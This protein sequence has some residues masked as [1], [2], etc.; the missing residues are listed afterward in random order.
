MKVQ[1]YLLPLPQI[2]LLLLLFVLFLFL[3][4]INLLTLRPHY[5]FGQRIMDEG[6]QHLYML[7]ESDARLQYSVGV[8]A[9]VDQPL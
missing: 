9:S 8:T 3:L 2:L 5:I 7:D 6:L 1:L 4:L